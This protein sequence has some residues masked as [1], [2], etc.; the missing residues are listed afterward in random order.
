MSNERGL[1]THA[2][3][4][5][6]DCVQPRRQLFVWKESIQGTS[7]MLLHRREIGGNEEGYDERHSLWSKGNGG[8][9]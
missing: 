5:L 3:V 9:S 7:L 8:P 2:D 1:I 4:R 6:E